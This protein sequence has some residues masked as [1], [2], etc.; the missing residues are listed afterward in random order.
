MEAYARK[1]K[2]RISCYRLRHAMATQRL[3]A[4]VDLSMI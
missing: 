2:H 3:N 4:D 1:E